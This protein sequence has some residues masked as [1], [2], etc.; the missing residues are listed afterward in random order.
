MIA[1]DGNISCNQLQY[2]N[3]FLLGLL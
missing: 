2:W 1:V 3:Y